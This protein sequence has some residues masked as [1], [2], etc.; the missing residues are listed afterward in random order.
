[1]LDRLCEELVDEIFQRLPVKSLLR[2][3]SLSKYWFSRIASPDFIRGHKLQSVNAPL[4]LIVKRHLYRTRVV[5]YTL[6]SESKFHMDV[7]ED[8]LPSRGFEVVGS[9]NGILCVVDKD[10]V[11]SLWNPTIRRK[12]T[13]P[14]PPYYIRDR[15]DW[16]GLGFGVDPITDDYKIVMISYS[17]TD[18]LVYSMKAGTWSLINSPTMPLKKVISRACL[19]NG[20]LYWVVERNPTGICIMTFDLSTNNCGSIELPRPCYAIRRMPIVIKDSLAVFYTSWSNEWI[21]VRR[22]RNNSS[23]WSM[24]VRSSTFLVSNPKVGRVLQ[25]TN[26]DFLLLERKW[27]LTIYNAERGKSRFA[28]KADIIDMES[29]AESLVLLD[30]GVICKETRQSCDVEAKANR[31]RRKLMMYR[32]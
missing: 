11:F 1:M 23:A 19:V 7:A 31:R 8:D 24:L 21:W 2:F 25:L 15:R 29:Y 22:E 12:L 28:S 14:V 18:P 16:L 5:Y 17:K 10:M 13:I 4:K 30:R 3:R 26:G 20:T 27:G 32:F 9:C 6:F